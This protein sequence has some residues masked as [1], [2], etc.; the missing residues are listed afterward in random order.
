MFRADGKT[1]QEICGVMGMS[2]LQVESI[3][4][5]YDSHRD[6]F[7][8]LPKASKDSASACPYW[9]DKVHCYTTWGTWEKVCR[10]G[11]TVGPRAHRGGL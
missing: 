9:S 11:S 7:D 1:P 10:C 8:T 3:L 4:D 5:H 2:P 6:E